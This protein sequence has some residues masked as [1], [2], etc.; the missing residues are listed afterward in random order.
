MRSVAT[1]GRST[2]GL[3]DFALRLEGKSDQLSSVG[4][5]S[6]Q[7]DRLSSVARFQMA[8]TND[9]WSNCFA[10]ALRVDASAPE[11]SEYKSTWRSRRRSA[12]NAWHG[13]E[14]REKE[15]QRQRRKTSTSRPR[16]PGSPDYRSGCLLVVE[17]NPRSPPA[18]GTTSSESLHPRE[19]WP[20]RGLA[21]RARRP[22]PLLLR[23][24]RFSMLFPA[25]Y[26]A[27]ALLA[28][29]AMPDATRVPCPRCADLLGRKAA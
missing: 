18:L 26:P 14:R 1:R 23:A 27:L 4:T 7:S 22:I 16:S 21:T 10:V 11:L 20:R 15:S 6:T 28:T 13:R 25:R 17:R 12:T 9:A 8:W 24:A 29:I 19:R 3:Q 2:D 5:R